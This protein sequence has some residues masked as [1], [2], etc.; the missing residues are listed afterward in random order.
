MSTLIHAYVHCIIVLWLGNDIT[1]ARNNSVCIRYVFEYTRAE[2][3]YVA[4][5]IGCEYST[6]VCTFFGTAMFFLE[7]EY[8]TAW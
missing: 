4:V 7:C 5:C 1:D 6:T 8:S 3:T 2:Y